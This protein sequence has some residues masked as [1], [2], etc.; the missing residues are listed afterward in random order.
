MT[1]MRFGSFIWPVNPVELQVEGGRNTREALF[2]SSSLQDEGVQLRRV[3]GRGVFTG[4]DAAAQFSALHAL[5]EAGGAEILT[6]PEYGPMRVILTELILLRGSMRMVEYT[7][8]FRESPA[9][10]ASSPCKEQTAT[11]R[12]GE[13]LWH[14]AARLAIPIEQLLT[15]NP[16]IPE[17]WSAKA[18]T[19]VRI[20]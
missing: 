5:L 1:T 10:I 16:K 15:L 18:G 17:P 4:P 20:Q 3:T 14:L 6:V 2:P 12:Q 7:F 8:T 13:T 11:L 9:E 19:E